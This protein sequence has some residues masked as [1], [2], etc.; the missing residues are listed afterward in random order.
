MREENGH[1]WRWRSNWGIAVGVTLPSSLGKILSLSIVLSWLLYRLGSDHA[2][3]FSN[4]FVCTFSILSHSSFINC[5]WSTNPLLITELSISVYQCDIRAN[6][7]YDTYLW[8]LWMV[9][10]WVTTPG[11]GLAIKPHWY[12]LTTS[13]KVKAF[14]LELH[15]SSF[16][17]DRKTHRPCIWFTDK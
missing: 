11:A 17:Q 8:W 12:Q 7:R 1:E 4:E 16:V 10:R 3:S 9:S 14:H 5:S 6:N 2:A 15:I 13:V